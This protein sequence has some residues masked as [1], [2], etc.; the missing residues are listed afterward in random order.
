MSRRMDHARVSKQ[1]R[2]NEEAGYQRDSTYPTTDRGWI[3]WRGGKHTG[4]SL[5]EI[6][7]CDPTFVIQYLY[8]SGN[9]FKCLLQDDAT[10]FQLRMAHQLQVLANRS[11]NIRVPAE[12]RGAHEFAILIDNE[13]VFSRIFLIRKGRKPAPSKLKGCRVA[14]RSSKLDFSIPYHFENSSLG[15]QRMASCFREMFFPDSAGEPCAEDILAFFTD[16]KN[17]DLSGCDSHTSLAEL[18]ADMIALRN[19]YIQSLKPH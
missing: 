16:R 15:L 12:K 9:C 19:M 18:D 10:W 17:F 4:K 11:Q 13:G 2:I 3:V 14:M 7:V 8:M 5:P 1:K 6:L